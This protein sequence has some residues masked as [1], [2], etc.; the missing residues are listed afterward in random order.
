[1]LGLGFLGS[2]F[3]KY[4]AQWNAFIFMELAIENG[5]SVTW[6]SNA[7]RDMIRLGR[8]RTYEE[9]RRLPFRTY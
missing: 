6:A 4:C 3:V 1:M 5:E 7:L 9:L 2:L 8:P